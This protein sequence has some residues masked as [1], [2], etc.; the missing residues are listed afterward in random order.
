MKAEDFLEELLGIN[1]IKLFNQNGN[2]YA[3]HKTRYGFA[4]FV[5][6]TIKFYVCAGESEWFEINDKNIPRIR[7]EIRKWKDENG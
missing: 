5:N 7:E 1:N 4:K 2:I 6:N 3:L